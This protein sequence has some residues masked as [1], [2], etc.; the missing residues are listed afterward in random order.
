MGY[1]DDRSTFFVTVVNRYND[2]TCGTTTVPVCRLSDI[3]LAYPDFRRPCVPTNLADTPLDIAA[4]A[5][6]ELREYM[7][8]DAE[9]KLSHT[10]AMNVWKF[11]LIGVVRMGFVPITL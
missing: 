5:P 10:G 3:S 1:R 6:P 7:L 8:Y 11:S 2:N 9:F 4:E